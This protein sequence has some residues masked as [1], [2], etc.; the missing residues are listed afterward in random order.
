VAPTG[1]LTLDGLTLR[2]GSSSFF[3]PTLRGGGLFN[4][5][6]TVTIT[7]STFSGNGGHAFGGGLYNNADGTLTLTNSILSGN[8]ASDG[9]GIYKTTGGTVTITHSTIVNNVGSAIGGGIVNPG[10]GTV[11][12]ADSTIASN[13]SF[14][15]GGG[16]GI[17]NSGSLTIT[18]STFS[19][20]SGRSGG[21]ISNILGTVIITSSTLSGNFATNGGGGISSGG[22]VALQN[23]IVALNSALYHPDC[24][25]VTSFG[26]NLIGTTDC[27]I[28]QPSDLTGDPGLDAFTDDG[29]PGNGHYPL[30]AT[31][32]AI[33]AGNDAVCPRRD[34]LGEKRHHPC[35]IG[36]IE[37]RDRP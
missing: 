16:G 12:I 14:D 25:G 5:G 2:G 35:D 24:V 28:L 17:R 8:S 18:N 31:S 23:T 37:F 9:G 11:T 19:G 27:A 26:N 36:A 1:D 10:G 32:Q 34:Q 30:L 6:G 13:R 22:I 33:D 20:N 15:P 3:E 7:S 21:A 4:N 29:T